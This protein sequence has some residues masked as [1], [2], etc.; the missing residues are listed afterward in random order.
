MDDVVDGR[1][2]GGK[3]SPGRV[4]AA[5]SCGAVEFVAALHCGCC[6]VLVCVEVAS[7]CGRWSWTLSLLLLALLKYVIYYAADHCFV[8]WFVILRIFD[9]IFVVFCAQT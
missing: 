6:V 1:G 7:C 5:V 9:G 2:V 8:C 4:E 3:R